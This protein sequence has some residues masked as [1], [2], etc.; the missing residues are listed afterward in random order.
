MDLTT[1][2]AT[3]DFVWYQFDVLLLVFF[4]WFRLNNRHVSSLH[5]CVKD[6]ALVE[7]FLEI[8]QQRVTNHSAECHTFSVIDDKDAFKEILQ[9]WVGLF[10]F[11]L[12]A[13][14][15]AQVEATSTLFFYVG[16][17][18]KTFEGILCEKHKVEQ[19]SDSP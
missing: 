9:F 5:L 7:L 4:R 6:V 8:S 11:F 14:N 10:D 17:Y 12:A 1:Y 13:D 15:L 2:E 16:Q 3:A 18:I 19:D